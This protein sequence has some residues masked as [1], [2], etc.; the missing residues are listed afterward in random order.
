MRGVG[1]GTHTLRATIHFPPNAPGYLYLLRY[2]HTT[3]LTCG[4]QQEGDK[5]YW[6]RDEGKGGEGRQVGGRV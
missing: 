2:Q 4:S 3:D 1:E 5:G 6:V